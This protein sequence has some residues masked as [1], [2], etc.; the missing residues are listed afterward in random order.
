MRVG[1][2]TQREGEHRRLR[3]KVQIQ[4][5]FEAKKATW[6]AFGAEFKL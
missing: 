6:I 4:R 5:P 1:H 2:E 3:Y